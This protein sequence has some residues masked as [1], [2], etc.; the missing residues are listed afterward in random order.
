VGEVVEAEVEVEEVVAVAEAAAAA[1][2]V[3]VM[4][5]TA[6]AITVDIAETVEL[7]IGAGSVENAEDLGTEMEIVV[8]KVHVDLEASKASE[9]DEDV[10]VP[11][12]HQTGEDL[13]TLLVMAPATALVDLPVGL[14]Q[15]GLLATAPEDHQAGLSLTTPQVTVL[16]TAQVGAQAGCQFPCQLVLFQFQSR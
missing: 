14:D 9:G 12:D 5:A 1:A 7:A 6:E 11:E 8:L 4:A 15:V 10:K 2:T 16:T 3:E 13:A